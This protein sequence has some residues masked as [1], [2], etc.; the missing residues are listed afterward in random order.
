M[1]RVG[2]ATA[3]VNPPLEA[4]KAP[5]ARG[6]S[7]GHVCLQGPEHSSARPE[8]F[9]QMSNDDSDAYPVSAA[10]CPQAGSMA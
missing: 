7:L 10:C 9:L 8:R 1:D 4:I 5:E 2:I 3:K 6:L